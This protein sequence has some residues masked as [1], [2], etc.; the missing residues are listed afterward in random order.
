MGGT[1]INEPT[2]FRM[3]EDPSL[4]RIFDVLRTHDIDITWVKN[5]VYGSS[6]IPESCP[7]TRDIDNLVV[8][9][10]EEGEIME[11][12]TRFINFK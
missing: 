11:P 10:L 7:V 1:R 2:S 8:C 9:D 3:D 12:A 6:C 4:T 5:Q